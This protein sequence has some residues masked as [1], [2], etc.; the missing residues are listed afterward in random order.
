MAESARLHTDDRSRALAH[1]RAAA[2]EDGFRRSRRLS[3]SSGSIGP[4]RRWTAT[5]LTTSA[6]D[7]W[8]PPSQERRPPAGGSCGR[9]PAP[10]GAPRPSDY[11]CARRARCGSKLS[12][13]GDR[14]TSSW[15]TSPCAGRHADAGGRCD[16]EPSRVG[17]L[18]RPEPEPRGRHV[19]HR[20][21]RLRAGEGR[22][23][24]DRLCHAPSTS[25]TSCRASSTSI[26]TSSMGHRRPE[27][28]G[29]RCA[30]RGRRRVRPAAAT[31]T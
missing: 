15:S 1:P 29:S 31:R 25:A 17:Q 8:P 5:S 16:I 12:N 6:G 27:R 20:I 28:A 14:G 22:A 9:T 7:S 10:R 18:R 21:H 23:T 19:S 26:A 4:T 24:A 30:R 13:F 3:G 11:D 2:P